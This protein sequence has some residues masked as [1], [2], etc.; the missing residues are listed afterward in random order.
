M[1]HRS[2]AD[3]IRIGKPDAGDEEILEAAKRA[4]CMEFIDRL[5]DGMNTVAGDSG[6]M[7]SGGERQRVSIARAILKNAGV[8]VLDEATAYVD[9]ENAGKIDK[10]IQE[11]TKGKTVVIIGHKL[12]NLTGAD[13]IVVL[14]SGRVIGTGTHGELLESCGHYRKLWEA[15]DKSKNW[16]IAG[17]LGKEAL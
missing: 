16:T 17:E 9:P 11:V 8:I 13:Q 15:A 12:Q 4:E 10:A 14:D 1:Y 5:P 2:I 7:L 3:N 6:K